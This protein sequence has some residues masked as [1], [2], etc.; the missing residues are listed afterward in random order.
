MMTLAMMTRATLGHSGR[1]LVASR[2]TRLAYVCVAVAVV[3]RVAMPILPAYG[4]VLMHVAAGAW[5]LAF[6][7][8][9]VVYAPLLAR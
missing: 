8:F 5:M 7:A 2:G 4:L 3:A 6:A 9:L 1:P